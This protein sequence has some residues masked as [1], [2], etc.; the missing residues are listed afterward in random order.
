[1]RSKF[2]DS[3]LNTILLLILI[4]L[5]IIALRWMFANKSTYLPGMTQSNTSYL[6]NG[7]TVPQIEGNKDDL[8][9]FS[10]EPGQEVSG[11][12]HATGELGNSYFFEANVPIAI[13]DGQK[14][15]ILQSHGQGTTDWMTNGPVSFYTD[16]DFS[17]LPKGKA[18]I[19]IT[20]D[21]PSGGESGLKIHSILI[22][23]VI[24]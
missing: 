18:Y 12:V 3:K 23:I 10:I 2:F 1:M 8:I 6:Q 4:I 21:D 13:L 22:P 17:N 11:K 5:M 14:N 7:K 20:Q 15:L 16:L 19:K 9:L 24:K